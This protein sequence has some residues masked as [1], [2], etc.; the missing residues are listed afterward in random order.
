MN[1]NNHDQ[2]LEE[3]VETVLASSKYGDISVDLVRTIA[4]QEL[5]K[6]A[7]MKEAVKATRG[8]LHQIGGAYLSGKETYGRWRDE[9]G[10][11]LQSGNREIVLAACRR[12]MAHHASTKERLPILDQFYNTLFANL[13]P[14]ASILDIACGLNPLALPWIPPASLAPGATYCAYDIYSGMVG[15]LNEFFAL[16]REQGYEIEGSAHACDILTAC[17]TQPFDVA[18][19]LK[20]IPCLEQ[21][22]KSAGY[23]LLRALNAK[24]LVVSFPIHSLGGK[25]KGMLGN[26]E[27]HFR[28]LVTGEN[29]E[30]ERFEFATELVFLVRK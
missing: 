3:L 27:T 15:F 30:I 17:P 16:I 12:V 7:S 8:K 10:K 21:V 20:T 24:Y 22:D 13:P 4:A 26:Y 23:R 2:Q 6:R 5:A 19:V 18:L 28:E 25:N 29:W 11:A 1:K 14:I 9:L